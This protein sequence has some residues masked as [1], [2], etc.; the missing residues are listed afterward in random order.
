MYL[1]S[2]SSALE[3]QMVC[4]YDGLSMILGFKVRDEGVV[5][6]RCK[7]TG[8]VCHGNIATIRIDE[9]SWSELGRLVHRII[10]T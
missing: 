1:Q 8:P 9:L 10:S 7:V 4:I 3:H 5:S 6:C 2:D